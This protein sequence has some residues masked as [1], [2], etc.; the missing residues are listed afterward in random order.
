MAATAGWFWRSYV[1]FTCAL[2]GIIISIA[3]NLHNGFARII[4]RAAATNTSWFSSAIVKCITCVDL[5]ACA[6]EADFIHLLIIGD[7]PEDL[8]Y[9]IHP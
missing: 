9:A 6:L 7:P 3:A 4:V 8:H 5:L 2:Q 1:R